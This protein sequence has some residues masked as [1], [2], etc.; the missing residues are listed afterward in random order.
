MTHI[1]HNQTG[2]STYAKIPV[3]KTEIKTDDDL[4]DNRNRFST[5]KRLIGISF[6]FLCNC[7]VG[8]H[9]FRKICL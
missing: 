1:N 6:F 5:L 2:S 8:V 7:C 3:V 9:H 4:N